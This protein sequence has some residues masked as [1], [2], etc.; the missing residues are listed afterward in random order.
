MLTK[1]QVG[2]N[3]PQQVACQSSKPRFCIP[4]AAAAAEYLSPC[5]LVH[6]KPSPYCPG[7]ISQVTQMPAVCNYNGYSM[8]YGWDA[9]E[10]EI[11][12]LKPFIWCTLG[13]P[14][15]ID[16]WY[17]FLYSG[18][19]RRQVISSHGDNCVTVYGQVLLFTN[20]KLGV[21]NKYSSFSKT[22]CSRPRFKIL[23]TTRR[24]AATTW[25]Q[26]T[27]SIRNN[28]WGKYCPTVGPTLW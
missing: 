6:Y 5:I 10:I 13:Y 2:V 9:Y 21:V 20:I 4:G 15:E 24:A 11:V 3:S 16:Q 18:S 12:L 22:E 23:K 19:I 1:C 7:C 8:Y 27:T 25:F 26:F 28:A 17:C 14:K